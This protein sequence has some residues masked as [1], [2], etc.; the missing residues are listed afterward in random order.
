[1]R[2]FFLLGRLVRALLEVFLFFVTVAFLVAGEG[3]VP[4]VFLLF[5]SNAIVSSPLDICCLF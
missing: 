1:M 3:V 4:P 5:F 2:Y